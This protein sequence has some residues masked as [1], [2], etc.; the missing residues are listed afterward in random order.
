MEV[1]RE[2][3]RHK[4]KLI[5]VWKSREAFDV[6]AEVLRK[7]WH[8][9]QPSPPLLSPHTQLICFLLFQTDSPHALVFT[10]IFKTIFDSFDLFF[11]QFRAGIS[12]PRYSSL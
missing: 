10:L 1:K 11:Q 5:N 9:F 4:D 6:A 12:L 8:T 2:K 3:W 7:R